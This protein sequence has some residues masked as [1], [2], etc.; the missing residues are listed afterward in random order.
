MTWALEKGKDWIAPFYRSIATCLTFGMSP[1]DIMTAQYATASRPVVRR[2][3]D[4]GPL[5]LARAQPRV[6]VIAGR[7]PAP[8]RRGPRARGQDPEDRPGRDDDHGRG[9]VEPGR[10]PRGP[11]LRRHPPAAVHLHRREQR[12]RDLGAARP[13]GRWLV[14]REPGGGLRHPRRHGRRLGRPR[15]LCGGARRGGPGA[16]R[17]RADPDRGQGH[18]PDR[19]LE[20]RPADEVPLRG[21]AGRR[22]GARSGAEVPGTAG[23][24]RDPHAGGGGADQRRDQGRRPRRD[25]VRGGAAGPRHADGDEVG[26]RRG[27]AV[28]DAAA[29]GDGGGDD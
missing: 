18:P 29:V 12:L 28:G 8:P 14:G 6:G 20:R 19:S 16:G 1:R 13:S 5:R 7:D 23:R 9:L 15:L 26:L 24:G 22:E 4:A 25:R 27:L 3:P 17:G 2:A 11:E 10:R 21:G